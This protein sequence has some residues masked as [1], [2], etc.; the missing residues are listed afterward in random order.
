MKLK[1]IVIYDANIIID[2]HKIGL[3]HIIQRENVQM[4][5]TSLVIMELKKPNREVVKKLLPSLIVHSYDVLEQY[6]VVIEIQN[7]LKQS[8]DRYNLS[9]TDVSVLHLASELSATLC[10]G[11]G[12]LRKVAHK[13]GVDVRGTIGIILQLYNE[14]LINKDAAIQSLILLNETNSRIA[15]HLINDAIENLSSLPD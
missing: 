12:N 7:A 14:Q 15:P 13:R 6:R 10:T 1:Q 4:H 9:L 3:L 5:T 8:K 2:L 11:D